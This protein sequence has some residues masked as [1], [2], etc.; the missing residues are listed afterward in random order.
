VAAGFNENFLFAHNDLLFF[1]Y[2]L[3]WLG[4][5]LYIAPFVV[6]IRDLRRFR[7]QRRSDP[8][9]RSYFVMGLAAA[10]G[11]AIGHL[12]DNL[13]FIGDI[14]RKFFALIACTYLMRQVVSHSSGSEAPMSS[15]IAEVRP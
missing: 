6:W 9:V 7:K 1:L 2:E 14:E 4:V 15:R 3:G 11:L 12:V 5:A 8:L 10:S 13:I